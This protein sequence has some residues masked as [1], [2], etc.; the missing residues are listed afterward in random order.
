MI[1]DLSLLLFEPEIGFPD[2]TSKIWG[3]ASKGIYLTRGCVMM[4]LDFKAKIA[5]LNLSNHVHDMAAYLHSTRVL[6]TFGYHA[7]EYAIMDNDGYSFGVVLLEL[8]TGRKPVDHTMPRG[9]QGLVT[10][11]TPRLSED[12]VKRCVDPK[13]KGE[14]PPKGVA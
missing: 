12:K 2:D 6:G 7:L 1:S 13:L 11:V 14:Y 9:Q 10:W 5:D 4:L 3:V 8:L